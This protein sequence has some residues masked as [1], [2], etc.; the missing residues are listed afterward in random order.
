MNEESHSNGLTIHVS[1]KINEFTNY[2]HVFSV[3]TDGQAGWN[4]D[5]KLPRH[6]HRHFRYELMVYGDELVDR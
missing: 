2:S 5:S 1:I 3:V 4:W 6:R